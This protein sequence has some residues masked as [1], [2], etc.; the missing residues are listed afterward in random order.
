MHFSRDDI[1]QPLWTF[2]F[3]PCYSSLDNCTIS[4]DKVIEIVS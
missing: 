4:F 2:V 3:L 1:A